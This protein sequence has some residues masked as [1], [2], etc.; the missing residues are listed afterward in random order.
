[1]NY[2]FLATL[3][4]IFLVILWIPVCTVAFWLKGLRVPRPFSGLW[5]VWPTQLLIAVA[6]IALSDSIGLRNPAGYSL[7]ITV[8]TSVV[9]A[10]GLWWWRRPVI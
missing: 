10:G 9:G 1:M 4:V 2:F 5:F 3:M 7:A 6:L 8:G